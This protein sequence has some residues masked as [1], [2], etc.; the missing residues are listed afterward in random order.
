MFVDV[1]RDGGNTA[2]QWI[3]ESGIVDL[4]IFTGPGPADVQRQYAEVTGPTAMPQQFSV[5]YHQCRWNY[6]NEADVHLVW[7]LQAVCFKR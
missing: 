6:K 2:T 1:S 5:G 4:F 7:H 3:A